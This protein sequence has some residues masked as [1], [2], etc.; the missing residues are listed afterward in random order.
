MKERDLT[1]PPLP[2]MT[3]FPH[4]WEDPC[5]EILHGGMWISFLNHLISKP[6]VRQE[7]KSE[8]GNDLERMNNRNPMTAMVDKATGFESDQMAKF[9]DWATSKYWG[10]MGD[11]EPMEDES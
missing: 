7:F 6:E 3:V 8:T 9:C 4:G 2:G 1:K 11:V 5:W 10:E